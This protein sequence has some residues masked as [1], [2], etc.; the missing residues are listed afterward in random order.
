MIKWIKAHYSRGDFHFKEV[1]LGAST[2][3]LL[4]MLGAIA[5]FV[6]SVLV[7]RLFGADG[8]GMY[9]LALSIIV[10]SSAIGRWGLDQSVLKHVS[11]FADQGE[12]GAVKETVLRAFLMVAGFSFAVTILVILMA[13]WI[14][15]VLFNKPE[16]AMMLQI[17]A[18]SI[19]PFSTLNLIAESLRALKKVGAYTL[20]HGLL[21]PVFSVVFLIAC[22]YISSSVISVAYAYLFSCFFTLI[23]ALLFW[24]GIFRKLADHDMGALVESVTL[25]KTATPMAWVTL[26]S[27]AMS[28]SETILLGV[29]HSSA[30]VGVYAA[31]LRLALLI[32]FVI[33]AFNS[34]LAPK[35]A[36]LHKQEALSEMKQMADSSVKIMLLLS[37]PAFGLFFIFPEYLLLIFSPGFTDASTA[38]MILTFGQLF[39]ILAGPVGIMLLMTGHEAVMRKNV[40]IA[41]AISFSLGVV[42]IPVYGVIGAAGAATSGMIALNYLSSWSVRNVLGIEPLILNPFSYGR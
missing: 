3:F 2:S 16:L 26:V 41:A 42:L 10:I 1:I 6:F 4:R 11:V 7:A 30:E 37:L 23:V 17:M 22:Y 13:Q 39:N 24:K 27:I 40:V 38:L 29:F 20:L 8:F 19:L 34:I 18:F 33:I 32:N 35:F 21:I 5:Q 31:A 36:A 14:S 15:V 12:W 25:L 28:F 9:T